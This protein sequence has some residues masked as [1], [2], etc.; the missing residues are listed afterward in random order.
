MKMPETC[1]ECGQPFELEV[2]FWYGTGYISY[3]LSF[4]FSVFTLIAWWLTIGISTEDHRFFWWMGS[5]AVF[6]VLLQPWLMRFSRVVYLY[7][8]VKYDPKYKESGVST[9]DYESEDYYRK[10]DAPD[11]AK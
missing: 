1:P 6:L 4:L 9:F 3:G 10:K 8:F 2:G 7:I 11:R 5:N